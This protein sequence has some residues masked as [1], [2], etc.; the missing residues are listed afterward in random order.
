MEKILSCHTSDTD[1]LIKCPYS[2]ATRVEGW[3]DA[4]ERDICQQGRDK[5]GLLRPDHLL[6]TPPMPCYPSKRK[7]KNLDSDLTERVWTFPRSL[8]APMSHKPRHPAHSQSQG[9]PA[10]VHETESW[11]LHRTQSRAQSPRQCVIV[12]MSVQEQEIQVKSLHLPLVLCEFFP[13]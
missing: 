10:C 7:K 12:R 8:Q 1:I 2:S 9:V 4:P 13:L 6:T 3:A 5:S 11:S